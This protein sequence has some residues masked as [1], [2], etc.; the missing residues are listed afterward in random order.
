MNFVESKN[1]LFIL[2]FSLIPALLLISLS[3]CSDKI[4][5]PNT[6]NQNNASAFLYAS[7]D[8]N[9]DVWTYY[10]SL[11]DGTVQVDFGEKVARA[12]SGNGRGLM[13]GSDNF[14]YL[15]DL[16]TGTILLGGISLSSGYDDF[17]SFSPAISPDGNRIAWSEVNQA[18]ERRRTVLMDATGGNRVTLLIGAAHETYIRFSPNGEYIAFFYED[19]A[20]SEAGL[21]RVN[22][23]GS[24]VT[25]L[26]TVSN[27]PN[28][29]GGVLD[30]SPDGS[31]IVF[32]QEE[33][34]ENFG[35]YVINSDG[36]GLQRIGSGIVPDWSPDG[37][38]I[39]FTFPYPS[40]KMGVMNP[41]GSGIE[42]LTP[43]TKGVLGR[44][45]ADGKQIL[46]AEY[47][48]T[49]DPEN[50]PARITIMNYATKST[51]LISSR[52]SYAGL[53]WVE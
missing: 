38:K 1:R 30:W 32:S 51:S 41:D 39:L 11:V 8:E 50:D 35:L 40:L 18:E 25:L 45:S 15:V 6:E 49:A 36:T 52:G 9:S 5:P 27:A 37:S 10:S 24:N 19:Y 42:V 2:I 48:I 20:T 14:L 13:L 21:Y 47:D 23:D 12:P 44:W 46:Y 34:A 7:Q 4:L 31:K 3:G 16:K 17:E 28:D 53:F 26:T 22:S 29:G 33:D 43:V